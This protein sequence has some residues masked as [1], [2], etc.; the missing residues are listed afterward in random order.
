[1]SQAEQAVQPSGTLSQ[2]SGRA[3]TVLESGSAIL[4]AASVMQRAEQAPGV[5]PAMQSQL[6]QPP[7]M[8]SEGK[9]G[10]RT[11]HTAQ[12]PLEDGRNKKGDCSGHAQLYKGRG[13]ASKPRLTA[14][15]PGVLGQDVQTQKGVSVLAQS[16]THGGSPSASSLQEK[17]AL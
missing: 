4:Q 10:E 17:A 6:G 9:A 11:V 5:E 16:E 7:R 12:R 15:S 2:Q 13:T 1:M 14:I 3:D 8:I